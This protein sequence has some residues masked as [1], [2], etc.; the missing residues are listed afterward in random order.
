MSVHPTSFSRILRAKS[1]VIPETLL[2]FIFNQ[3]A[4]PPNVTFVP[5]TVA[6]PIEGALLPEPPDSFFALSTRG[7]IVGD[8]AIR[9]SAF[10]LAIDA[11]SHPLISSLFNSLNISFF[12]SNVNVADSGILLISL[13]NASFV[14]V[15][16]I[17]E[18]LEASLR[19]LENSSIETLPFSSDF[20]NHCNPA[21]LGSLTISSSVFALVCFSLLIFVCNTCAIASIPPGVN[22]EKAGC[23][24]GR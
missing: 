10:S 1:G 2:P 14:S 17:I 22:A 18:S 5:F 23:G 11:I 20:D 3:E 15:F 24:V 7:R 21:R 16:L 13:I 9:T 8:A 4:F 6:C 12:F 19:L